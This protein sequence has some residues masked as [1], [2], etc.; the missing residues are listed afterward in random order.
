MVAERVPPALTLDPN[1]EEPLHRQ[2]YDGIRLSVLSGGLPAGTRLASTR[3]MA[4]ELGVS[5]N[6]VMAAFNQLLAEGYL[7]GKIGSGT[8]VTRTLPDETLRARTALPPPESVARGRGSSRRGAQLIATPVSAARVGAPTAFRPGLPAIDEFPLEL[9]SRIVA[10]KWRDATLDLLSYG[11][12]A[13]Y[14]PLREAITGHL[15]VS[16]SVRCRPEQVGVLS[17]SQP[18]LD[19]AARLLL[20]PGAMVWPEDPGS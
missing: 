7:Q 15:A 16:R 2:L 9:W 17:G 13:G 10:R 12:P 14:V 4:R 1:A 18:A 11:D 3:T 19:L 8:Y 20:D 6:T 5:R